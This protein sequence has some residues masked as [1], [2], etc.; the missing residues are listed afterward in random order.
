MQHSESINEITKALAKAQSSMRGARENS[1]NGGFKNKYAG[2]S[3]VWKA[4]RESLNENGLAVTQLPELQNGVMVLNTILMHESGQWIKSTLVLQMPSQE[5]IDKNRKSASQEM[6]SALTYAR[7]YALAS[8]VGVCPATDDD[9]GEKTRPKDEK[10]EKPL[11][12]EEQESAQQEEIAWQQKTL[13]RLKATLD[14]DG[15]DGSKIEVFLDYCVEIEDSSRTKV[16]SEMIQSPAAITEV[17]NCY[18]AWFEEKYN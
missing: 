17:K 16:L 1:I 8:I 3:Q 9:D 12:K 5:T 15:Q 14:K 7:R 2:L 18:R 13:S 11:S 10:K 6:G 4:C